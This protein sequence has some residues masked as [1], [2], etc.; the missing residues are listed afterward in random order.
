MK[1]TLLHIFPPD[2]L[3]VQNMSSKNEGYAITHVDYVHMFLL[4]KRHVKTMLIQHVNYMHLF[5]RKFTPYVYICTYVYIAW[6]L[7]INKHAHI[8]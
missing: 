3:R 8:V 7:H 1:V 5:F 6:R 4:R 2:H